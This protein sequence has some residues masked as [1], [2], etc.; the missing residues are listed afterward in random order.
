MSAPAVVGQHEAIRVLQAAPVHSLLVGNPGTGKTH[1]AVW[2]ADQ[3]AGQDGGYIKV[4]GGTVNEHYDS[5]GHLFA[6]IPTEHGHKLGAYPG[7]VIVDEIQE[8]KNIAQFY[9]LLD[10]PVS[11][12]AIY[13]FTTTDEGNL[14]PAFLSRL[15][16]VTLKPYKQEELAEIAGADAPDLPYETRLVIAKLS[17]GSPRQVKALSVLLQQVGNNHKRIVQPDEVYGVMKYLGYEMGLNTREI[18]LLRALRGGS[19]SIS[20]LSALMGTGPKT[21]RLWE[22]SLVYAGLMTISSKGRDLTDKGRRLLAQLEQN[23][24]ALSS[25]DQVENIR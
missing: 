3:L 8:V 17:W 12:S 10:K 11:R 14:P 18:G 1:L 20:T 2:Y 23:E 6:D 13:L 9:P 16:I 4:D 19:R 21:I 24:K 25:M 5:Y 15:R 22:T 7:P